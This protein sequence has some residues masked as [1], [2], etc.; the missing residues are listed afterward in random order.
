M[1]LYRDDGLAAIK[2]TSVLILD[3]MGKNILTLFEEECLSITIE[4]NLIETDILDVTFNLAMGKFFP[5]RK[6]NNVPLYMNV[7][8]NH[9]S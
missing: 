7:K 5:F 3:K 4:I 2:N 8:P 6:P 1:R 9:P